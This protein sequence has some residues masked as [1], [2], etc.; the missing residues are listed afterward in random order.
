MARFNVREVACST[1]EQITQQEDVWL[2]AAST[3][4]ALLS[5]KPLN[6]RGKIEWSRHFEGRKVL[7]ILFKFQV[8]IHQSIA[9]DELYNFCI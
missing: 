1:D 8:I 5:L 2:A 4:I 9:L 7:Y 3:Q 6:F